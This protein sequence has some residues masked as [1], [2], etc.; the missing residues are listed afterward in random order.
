MVV[1]EGFT[2]DH[3]MSSIQGIKL[4]RLS[5]QTD[6]FIAVK[7]KR[8]DAFVTANT[9]VDMFV[10]EQDISQFSATPIEGTGYR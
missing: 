6:G 7:N 10:K 4:V 3:L 2:S 1:V 5:S 8:A 9:T